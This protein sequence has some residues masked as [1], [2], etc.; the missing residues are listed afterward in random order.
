MNTKYIYH[1]HPP[2]TLSLCPLPSR[3]TYPLERISFTLLSFIFL[4]VFWQFKGWIALVFLICIYC[5]LL[6]L[7][8]P[9][10]LSPS[11]FPVSPIIQQVTVHCIILYSY[12]DVVC[13]N[14]FYSLHSFS[15]SH[16]PVI[17]SDRPTNTENNQDLSL[18]LVCMCVCI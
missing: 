1:N 4:S 13:F 6:W 2:F 17:P 15:L 16:L 5:A 10:L 8:V 3:D 12:A 9:S 18:S 14:I 11:L 7:T